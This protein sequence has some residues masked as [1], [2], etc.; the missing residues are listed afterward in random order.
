MGNNN[1]NSNN[2]KQSSMENQLIQKQLFEMYLKSINNSNNQS[3]QNIQNNLKQTYS[4]QNKNHITSNT[5]VQKTLLNNRTM[6]KQFLEKV[7]RDYLNKKIEL[8]KE[9][10]HKINY[11]IKQLNL[12]Y[13]D[14]DNKN[15]NLYVNEGTA[16]QKSED[17][18]E[19]NEMQYEREYLEGEKKRR[20]KFRLDQD[21]RRNEFKT[22]IK[23]FNNTSTNPYKLFKLNKNFNLQDLKDAYKKLAVI[24]HPDRPNGSKAKF[25]LVTKCYLSLQEDL[26][27]RET[28]KQYFKLK[29]ESRDYIEVQRSDG[30]KNIDMKNE[31]F[32]VNRFNQI[33]NENKLDNPYDMG[34]DEWIKNNEY[35]TDDIPKSEIFSDKFNLDLFNSVF[36]DK[37]KKESKQIVHYNEPKAMESCNNMIHS[38]I[39]IDNLSNFGKDNIK[40]N[41]LNYTDYK[42][43][44]TKTHL[45]DPTNTNVK[46]Y[47]SVNELKRDRSN[48][49]FIASD[50]D[51]QK[52]EK[53][54]QYEEAM[55]A[56]RQRRIKIQDDLASQQYNKIH[57]IMLKR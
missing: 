51:I 19:K 17:N 35:D 13:D 2:T 41:E 8:S 12:E 43:A 28:D 48:I 11:F 21:Q 1:S 16:I 27:K 37:S 40:G 4:N 32:D 33:Y 46:T 30:Y 22:K 25:Q 18:F 31:D 42:L 24:T 38:Q 49:S 34:Y 56:E 9:K 10:Y 50:K 45:I 14:I 57:Q 52:R 23:E 44:Y 6:Q 55:E 7:K 20:D 47:N 26:K 15:D 39:G 53:Y 36:K 54:K 5:E 29:D 3:N